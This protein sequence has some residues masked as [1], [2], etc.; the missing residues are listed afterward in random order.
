MTMLLVVTFVVAGLHTLAWL[1]RSLAYRKHLKETHAL[2][3][4]QHVRRFTTRMRN[5]H[6][7]VISSFLTLAITGMTLKFSYTP[8]AYFLSRLLG[9]FEMAGLLHRMGAIVTFGYFALHL[10]DLFQRKAASGNPGFA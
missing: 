2:E 9:G 1:P 4:K 6:L 8:W 3:S 5:M 10:V 7:M